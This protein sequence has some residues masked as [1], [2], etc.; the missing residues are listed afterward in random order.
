MSSGQGPLPPNGRTFPAIT[1]PSSVFGRTVNLP[2]CECKPVPIKSRN[3]QV[4]WPEGSVLL[5]QCQVDPVCGI[6]DYNTIVQI[7]PLNGAQGDG[8]GLS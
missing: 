3:V 5:R 4:H 7:T 1:Y 8:H 6:P 2:W